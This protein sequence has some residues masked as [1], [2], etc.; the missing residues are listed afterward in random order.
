M[1]IARRLKAVGFNIL[2]TEN[3]AKFLAQKGIES[4]PIKKLHEGRPNIADA[5]KNKE[6]QL[7]INTPVGRFS[8]FDDSY[9]RI[10]A[11]QHK[12]PYITT[13]AAARA[14]VEAIESIAKS[15]MAP[16]ALQDYHAQRIKMHPDKKVN[17]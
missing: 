8:K 11:I 14:S 10:M 15:R 3:T 7:I 9:I 13:M 16:K 5:I 2:A 1:E 4:T 12:L 6:V 17:V